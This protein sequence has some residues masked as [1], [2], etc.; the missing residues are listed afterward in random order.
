MRHDVCCEWLHASVYV[1]HIATTSVIL[2]ALYLVKCGVREIKF[3]SAVVYGQAVRGSD[4]IANDHNDVGASQ[5]GTHDTG[6]L[7]IPVSPKHEAA[8]ESRNQ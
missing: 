2:A 6:R 5:C 3:F 8:G 4:V 1:T 7:L